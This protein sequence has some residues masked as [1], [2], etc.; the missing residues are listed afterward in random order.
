MEET[1]YK[2]G[3]PVARPRRYNSKGAKQADDEAQD[4]LMQ[5]LEKL[6]RG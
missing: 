1:Q 2:Q 3:K 6:V 5:R 4:S